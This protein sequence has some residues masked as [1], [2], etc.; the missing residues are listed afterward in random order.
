MDGVLVAPG[1][2]MKH[3]TYCIEF[4]LSLRMIIIWMKIVT[5]K[6]PSY[7]KISLGL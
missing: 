4:E 7:T 5:Y 2:V 1:K 6:K 3:E